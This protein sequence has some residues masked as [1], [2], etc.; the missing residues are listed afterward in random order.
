MMP[1]PQDPERFSYPIKECPGL[2][3]SSL[4][5]NLLD[6]K[7]TNLELIGKWKIWRC[8]H[9]IC[10]K[11]LFMG[12]RHIVNCEGAKVN[13]DGLVTLLREC[14]GLVMLDVRDCSG[15]DENND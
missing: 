2:V 8:H 15:F 11:A 7:H 13:R 10:P 4:P 9:W 5:I 12:V 3:A 1:S 6:S 14:K